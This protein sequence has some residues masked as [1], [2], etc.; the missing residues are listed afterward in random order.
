MAMKETASYQYY[1]LKPTKKLCTEG[2]VMIKRLASKQSEKHAELTKKFM[3]DDRFVSVTQFE[4]VTNYKGTCSVTELKEQCMHLE[5]LEKFKCAGLSESDLQFHMKYKL[6][7]KKSFKNLEATVLKERLDRINRHL[8]VYENKITSKSE[9]TSSCGRQNILLLEKPNSVA[10]QLLKFSLKNEKPREKASS[11][12]MDGIKAIETDLFSHLSE[13]IDIKR[14]RTKT[15]KLTK[16][17]SKLES[18]LE[19][20][21]SPHNLVVDRK[22]KWDVEQ[23]I[24]DKIIMNSNKVYTCAVPNFY[25]VRNNEIIKLN[26]TN[27]FPV[28]TL[29]EKLSTD[30]IKKM[31]KFSNYQIGIPSKIIYIQNLA[32]SITINDL[33][34]IFKFFQTNITSYKV[35]TG[36]LKGKAFVTFDDETNCTTAFAKLNGHFVRNKAMIFEYGKMDAR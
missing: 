19:S 13:N 26:N 6:N 29:E 5:E 31:P 9:D 1:E 11:H 14:V 20:H 18:Q 16:R 34:S 24:P 7:Q 2:D 10:T 27:R 12:P 4:T 3:E 36:R 8:K 35:L 23:I 17:M 22:T 21:A 15:R 25:T 32:H 30:D 28:Q 33:K